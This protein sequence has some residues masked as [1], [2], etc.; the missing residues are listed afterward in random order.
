[1][2]VLNKDELK[3]C[4]DWA[5]IEWS[6]GN[7]IIT[8]NDIHVILPVYVVDVNDYRKNIDLYYCPSCGECS[9]EEDFTN[10]K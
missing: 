2:K 8:E 4:C 3:T 6:L 7:I 9:L 1:M 5:E 10:N